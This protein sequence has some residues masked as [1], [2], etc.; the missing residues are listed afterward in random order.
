MQITPLCKKTISADSQTQLQAH[1]EC[2]R[3]A[4]ACSCRM[5][6]ARLFP[7]FGEAS[8]PRHAAL[9]INS[10]SVFRGALL[11]PATHSL[12]TSILLNSVYFIQPNITS[13]E[14]ASEGFT[15]CTHTTSLT[16][17]LVMIWQFLCLVSC[18]ILKSFSYVSSVSLHFLS[19]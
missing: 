10:S 19:L 18:F 7:R 9:K 17:D 15:T 6:R 16:Q 8:R 1:C 13:S 14:F 11:P 2:L 5:S 4:E 12:A 3:R